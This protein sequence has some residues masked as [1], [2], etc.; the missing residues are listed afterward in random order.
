MTKKAVRIIAIIIILTM[1]FSTTVYANVD[2]SEYINSYITYLHTPGE[3]KIEIWFDVQANTKSDEVGVLTVILRSSEDK[4]NWTTE[5]T[6]RYY[7]YP[8]MLAYNVTK[9]ISHL[10]FSG[11]TG[12]YYQA[13]V[14]IWVGNDGDGDSRIIYT[15]IL[16]T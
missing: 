10:E 9:Y 13:Q 4:E 1:C 14:T 16:K 5:E 8:D 15:P 3:G 12:L 7:D 6:F 11:E 2:A